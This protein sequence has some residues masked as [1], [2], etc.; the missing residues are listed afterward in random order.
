LRQWKDERFFLYVH[1]M[2]VHSPY[3]PPRP[4]RAQFVGEKRGR[5]IHV[6][7]PV[8]KDA[9]AADVDY[10]GALYD[11]E[12]RALDDH[13]HALLTEVSALGLDSS[14]TVVLT[15]DHGEEFNEHGGMGHGTTLHGEL[16]H[17][18]L[19]VR[20][21]GGGTGKRLSVPV[22]LV[23]LWP[24]LAELTATP[25]TAGDGVSL[26]ALLDDSFEQAEAR[27]RFL[28]AELGLQASTQRA[29]HKLIRRLDLSS[30]E[31]YDLSI[32]PLEQRPIRD[33]IGWRAD[34]DRALAGFLT[35]AIPAENDGPS[36]PLDPATVE[37]LRA[38]GYG[39]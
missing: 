25:A 23:D 4:Y 22:S 38:L 18:P 35:R 1:Y 10:S 34:L 17:V 26:A 33:E 20:L 7:G 2:D 14:T 15:A 30:Q 36:E 29:N 6:H 37:K 9:T 12:I 27:E 13:L 8:P 16:I 32:D 11:A 5:T 39:S 21:P 3:K 31:A 24:T 28:Y 19:I